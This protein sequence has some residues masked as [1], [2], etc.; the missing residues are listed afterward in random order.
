MLKMSKSL[1][2]DAHRGKKAGLIHH[3]KLVVDKSTYH[4]EWVKVRIW[5]RWSKKVRILT[6]RPEKREQENRDQVDGDAPVGEEESSNLRRFLLDILVLEKFQ[7]RIQR[8]H[9]DHS[10]LLLARSS[11]QVDTSC[12]S[13]AWS[14]TANYLRMLTS[15]HLWRR[16]LP[17]QR[18]CLVM[19]ICVFLVWWWVEETRGSQP[20]ENESWNEMPHFY[21][22]L[23]FSSFLAQVIQ[24][25]HAGREEEGGRPASLYWQL[26]RDDIAVCTT[27]SLILYL[28]IFS[29]HGKI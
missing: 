14:E 26:V 28:D 23:L 19:C 18:W 9:F 22:L 4:H 11:Y 24:I 13:G 20:D 12:L 7:N 21:L 1:S 27:A 3:L 25:H 15:R 29:S 8:F 17:M 6:K 10:N 16:Q 2:Q 5:R